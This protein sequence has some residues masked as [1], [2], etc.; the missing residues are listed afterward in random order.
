MTKSNCLKNNKELMKEYD[1]EKNNDIDL[2]KL[3]T[4]SGKKVWWKCKNGH[5]WEA[6]IVNRTKGQKCPVCSGKRIIAGINDIFTIKPELKNDWDYEKN[7]INPK[8]I[9][10]GSNKDAYWICQKGHKYK[11]RISHRTSGHGCPYCAGNKVLEGY[12]DLKTWCKKNNPTIL[13][14][15]DYEK[16]GDFPLSETRNS[17]KTVWWKCKTCGNEYKNKIRNEISNI[18]CPKCNKRNRTSFPEQ[19]I[20][21]YVKK[22]FPDAINGYKDL[23]NKITELDIYIPS[24]K[25]GIEYDGKAWHNSES[26]R[27]K[28]LLKYKACQNNNIILIRFKEKIGRSDKN[29]CDYLIKSSYNRDIQLFNEEL[30]TF[31]NN[32]KNIDINLERDR[33]DIYKQYITSMREKSLLLLFPTIADEW[34]YEKN[35]PLKPDMIPAFI[36]KD[37]YFKC[38]NNHSYKIVVSKRTSRGDGCP[39]CSGHKVLVGYNDLLTTNPEIASEWNYNK[40]YPLKPENVS[41]GYDKKVWWIC[42]KC[43]RSFKCSPNTRTSGNVGCSDCKGGVAKQI[44]QYDLNGVMI[45]KYESCS[46]AARELK[47]S[48]SLLSRACKDYTVANNYQWRYARDVRKENIDPYV[49]SLFNNKEVEQYTLDGKYIKTFKSITIAKKETGASKIGD[50]CAGNRKTSGGYIWKYAI[51]DNCISKK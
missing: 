28:E 40:N 19:A 48:N 47:I 31:I 2:E 33:N 10:V 51:K 8:M 43:H 44:I 39:Y 32:Y 50:V 24:K 46:A 27:K 7:N 42:S 38:K 45:K 15:W 22:I 18:F 25:I 35:Y 20:Y 26:A 13:E 5:E 11:M 4:G 21:Y 29:T 41:K 37:F 49:P 23:S 9:S 36:N 3:T 30:Q 12:N 34:D 16:N 1:Y 17:N 14:K 6:I